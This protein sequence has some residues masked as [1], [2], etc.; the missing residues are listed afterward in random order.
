MPIKQKAF[1]KIK[2][3]YEVQDY[4]VGNVSY[5]SKVVFDSQDLW[6]PMHYA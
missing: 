1:T 2:E 6:V 3:A 5:I 4:L